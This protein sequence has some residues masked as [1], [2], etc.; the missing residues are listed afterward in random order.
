LRTIG[1]EATFLQSLQSNA[2][3]KGRL[4]YFSWTG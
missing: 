4:L 1:S 2:L 3:G